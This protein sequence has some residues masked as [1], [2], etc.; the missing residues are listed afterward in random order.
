MAQL[1]DFLIVKINAGDGSSDLNLVRAF[2][3]A[4]QPMLN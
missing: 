1:V 3:S 2:T 4:Q